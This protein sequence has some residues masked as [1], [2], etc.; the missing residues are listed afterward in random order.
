MDD[1]QTKL[2]MNKILKNLLTEPVEVC[3]LVGLSLIMDN[4]GFRYV[5]F[6]VLLLSEMLILFTFMNYSDA[7]PNLLFQ[8]LNRLLTELDQVSNL[9]FIGQC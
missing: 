4:V 1:L 9:G 7:Q 3:G 2:L 5:K 8:F 6:D